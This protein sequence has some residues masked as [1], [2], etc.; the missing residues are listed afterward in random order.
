MYQDGLIYRGEYM[1]NY[2]PALE[3]VISDIEVDHIEIEEKMYYINYFVAGTDNELMIATTRP[4][5]LLADMAVAVHPKDK[6]YKKMIGRT[7]L[8]PIINREIP[9]I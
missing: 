1:V 8:L 7:V 4:E 6:R 5:T 9:I 2:S 3:S